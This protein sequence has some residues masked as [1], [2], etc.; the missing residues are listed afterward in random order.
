MKL[1]PAVLSLL[2]SGYVLAQETPPHSAIHPEPRGGDWWKERAEKLN[3]SVADTQDTPLIFIGDSIT[4]GWESA[5]AKVWEEYYTERK[6]VN[7]GI[8]GDR[9]QHVLWRLEN[10][11]LK[12][13]QPKAAVIMIGTNNSNGQD[14]TAD[15]INEGVRAIVDKLQKDVPETRIL[16]L[17]IFPRGENINTQRGKILQINQILAKLHDGDKVHYL[18]IGPHFI[19]EDGLIPKDIMPDFLHLTEKGYRL[20][21]EAIEPKLVELLGES[22][23]GDGEDDASPFDGKWLF[24]IRGPEG[25]DVDIPTDL[26][27]EG[28]KVAGRMARGP[29]QWLD[30]EKGK[31]DGNTIQFQVTRDR[32]TGGDMTY[33]IE[34]A[35]KDKG[36]VG[37]VKANFQG[38]DVEQSFN[39]RRPDQ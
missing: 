15:Q 24:T 20:W 14:N 23:G 2:L 34:D 36:I 8:G 32:P 4:Q 6:A 10:G 33:R 28:D 3:Q 27:I 21:A 37:T 18:D 19:T 9:T 35:I 12:G 1:I 16:L 38:Q 30:I 13:I 17:G 11:N 7:L 31:V 39:A 25:E 26:E 22:D 29:D 5:G